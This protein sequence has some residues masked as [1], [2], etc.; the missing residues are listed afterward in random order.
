MPEKQVARL[1]ILLPE[2]SF[3]ETLYPVLSH[4]AGHLAKHHSFALIDEYALRD[5]DLQIKILICKVTEK[6]VQRFLLPAQSISRSYSL[7]N[8]L[9]NRPVGPVGILAIRLG[10]RP[11]TRTITHSQWQHGGVENR[12]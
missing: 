9:Y 11:S 10:R 3:L 1:D 2:R 5:L 6:Y 12:R 8:L 7:D 4:A